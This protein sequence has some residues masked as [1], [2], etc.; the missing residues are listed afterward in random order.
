MRTFNV[1]NNCIKSIRNITML[2]YYIKSFNIRATIDLR[3]NGIIGIHLPRNISLKKMYYIMNELKEKVIMN[4][5]LNV[6]RSI[7]W[8]QNFFKTVKIKK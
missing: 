4:A 7:K 1:D 8:Y 3:E 6:T 5:I 2:L